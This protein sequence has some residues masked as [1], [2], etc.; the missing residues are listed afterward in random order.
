M[1][2]PSLVFSTFLNLWRGLLAIG[3]D[4]LPLGRRSRFRIDAITG[5]SRPKRSIR[6]IGDPSRLVVDLAKPANLGFEMQY[7]DL[8]TIMKSAWA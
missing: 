2:F 4:C 6:E 7:S 5:D 3:L 1:T 8:P